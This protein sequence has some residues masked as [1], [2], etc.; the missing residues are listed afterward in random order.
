MCKKCDKVYNGTNY[1]P[2]EKAM[3]MYYKTLLKNTDVCKKEGCEEELV[4][5]IDSPK[6]DIKAP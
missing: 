4:P 1:L 3:A 6:D 5:V 2:Y